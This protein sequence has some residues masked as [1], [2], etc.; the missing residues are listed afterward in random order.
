MT[1]SKNEANP[2]H[3]D[4]LFAISGRS[5]K[6]R[7]RTMNRYHR[8]HRKIDPSQGDMLQDG[9]QNYGDRVEI[10]PTRLAF[11]EWRHANLIAP[12]LD[13]MRHYRWHR[14]TQHIVDRDYAGL[15]MFDPLNIRYATDSTNISCG[16]RIIRFVQC[17]FVPTAIW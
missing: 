2:S 10:G 16:I 6:T 13:A 11:Q 4:Y 17:C 15:L 8:D 5:L 7:E 1:H 12:N 9:S 14:L 3:L